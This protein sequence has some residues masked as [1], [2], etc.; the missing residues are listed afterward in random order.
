[1]NSANFQNSKK[2]NKIDSIKLAF[3]NIFSKNNLNLNDDFGPNCF[4]LK[5]DK[6][7]QL[8]QLNNQLKINSVKNSYNSRKKNFTDLSINYKVVNTE[9]TRKSN[10]SCSSFLKSSNKSNENNSMIK[11]IEYMCETNNQVS[12][13]S[14]DGSKNFSF[15]VWRFIDE[16]AEHIYTNYEKTKFYTNQINE[17]KI[18]VLY[19]QINVQQ[20][21]FEV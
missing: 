8:Y 17:H 18:D 13:I 21:F 7:F 9:E 2:E 5:N 3:T 16:L 15:K 12:M 1:M 20:L 6:D 11:F 4:F 10:D 19:F 14:F